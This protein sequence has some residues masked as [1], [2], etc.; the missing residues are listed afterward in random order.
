MPFTA[1]LGAGALGGALAHRLALR[2]RTRE[3]R[4]IDESEAIARGKA[5]DILQSSPVDGFS[6]Q[7]TTSDSLAAAAG[8]DVVIVADAAR[9]DAE[10]AGEAGLALM[11]RLVA[12]EGKA[13]LLFAGAN[14][15]TLMA[16]V[17]SELHVSPGRVIGSA[18]GA[19]QSAVRALAALDVNGS[20]V[21]VQLL[22]VGV[23]PRAAVIA[24]ESATAYG[25]PISSAIPPHR[26]AAISSRLPGL[27][28]PGPQALAS[29]GSRVAEALAQGSRR[30]FCCFVAMQDTPLR[31][32][33]IAMP[34]VLARGGIERIVA[35]AL[36][37]Q[38]Q[39]Q[40]ENAATFGDGDG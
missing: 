23:P 37:R 16:R 24:W 21:D 7:L 31:Q 36:S 14:Q 26:L 11:R 3:I 40:L 18:P 15:R 17:V 2:D 4:L 25:Q 12:I 33:V 9:G 27:W 20:G 38:E 19:L 39:T 35:P 10:H 6:T 8:A 28:P 5:L 34:V 1:I 13:P 29:A 30:R 32:A 22:L